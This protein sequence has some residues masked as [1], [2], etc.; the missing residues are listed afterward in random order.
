MIKDVETQ[1]HTLDE[2]KELGA[3][4][5]PEPPV[6]SAAPGGSPFQPGE[7][8]LGL[9]NLQNCPI[10]NGC[11]FKLISSVIICYGNTD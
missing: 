3:N 2:Q 11:A 7:A 10:T 9:W 5:P 6:G 4:C 1:S 8:D